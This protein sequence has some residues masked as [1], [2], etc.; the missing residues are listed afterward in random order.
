MVTDWKSTPPV[1]Q[2]MPCT[3]LHYTDDGETTACAAYSLDDLPEGESV[4]CNPDELVTCPV[5]KA[6]EQMVITVATL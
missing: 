3:G 1:V 4:V 2:G 5:C 6:I